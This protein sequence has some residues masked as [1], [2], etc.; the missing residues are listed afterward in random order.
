MYLFPGIVTDTKDP[1]DLARVMVK[2]PTFGPEIVSTLCRLVA[3]GAG[4]DRGIEFI[5][6]VDDEVLCIGNTVDSLY[7]LGGLWSSVDLAPQKNSQAAPS[8]SVEKRVIRSRLEKEILLDDGSDGGIRII[9]GSGNKIDLK[10]AS[11]DLN[12]EVQGNITLKSKTGSITI[13]AFQGVSVKAMTEFSAEAQGTATVKATGS[14]T[15]E[16]TANVGVKSGGLVSLSG[17]AVSLG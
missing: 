8:G 1:Q 17:S 12:I 5:P 7:I 13:D 16:G 9:D 3:L 14:A 2:F 11:G 4:S 15:L 6:E 10:T